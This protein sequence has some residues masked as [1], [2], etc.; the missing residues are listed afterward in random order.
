MNVGVPGEGGRDGVLGD[1]LGDAR[2][3]RRD[4]PL[5]PPPRLALKASVVIPTRDRPE[6]LRALLDSLLLQD[7]SG[8][9]VIVVDNGSGAET[10]EL[11]ASHPLAIRALRGEGRGPAAARN[12]GWREA[13]GR[14][15]CFT[16]DDCRVAP[17]CGICPTRGSRRHRR[18]HRRRPHRARA[19]RGGAASGVHPIQPRHR[20]EPG[21]PHLQ[22]RVPAG[23]ARAAWWLRRVVP[24]P[25]GRGHGAWRGARSSPV[26]RRAS[27]TAR[28][29]GTPSTTSAGSSWCGARAGAWTCRGSSTGIRACATTCSAASSGSASTRSCAAAIAGAALARP[30]RGASLAL[31]L[32]YLRFCRRLHGSYPGAVAHLPAHVA[33]D[34]AELA[35]LAAGSARERTL[36]L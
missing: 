5:L 35:A 27:P 26:L 18:C 22:H 30:T 3:A 20:P 31:A 25:R 4:A 8:F 14:L 15:V 12:V 2:R 9:E 13:K 34:G 7:A 19:G 6:R 33:V 32:P 23:A 16:D 28:W 1:R 10:A 36:V 11:L 24:Q 29:C 21:L 17:G